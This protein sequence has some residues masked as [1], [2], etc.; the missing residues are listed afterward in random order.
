MI[1][2]F[3]LGVS[4]DPLHWNG[5]I[6]VFVTALAQGTLGFAGP[7]LWATLLPA[8]GVGHTY[9]LSYLWVFQVLNY[10]HHS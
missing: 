3:I 8:V 9:S 10:I 7:S 1:G 2:Q 6:A 5:P 4:D